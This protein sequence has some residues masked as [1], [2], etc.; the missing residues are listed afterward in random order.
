MKRKGRTSITLP[1]TE[2][3]ATL[4]AGLFSP[5]F[6][7]VDPMHVGE[8]YRATAIA[9]HYGLRLSANSENIDSDALD[10]LI[11]QY[12]THGFVIDRARGIGTV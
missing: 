10:W 8:S 6:N 12:P 11:T 3:A 9:K 1:A 5:I 4:T 7:Q 2:I